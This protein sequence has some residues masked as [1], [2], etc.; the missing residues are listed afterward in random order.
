M[1]EPYQLIVNN[2]YVLKF[3]GSVTVFL[4]LVW[5]VCVLLDF[6][7][8]LD[9]GVSCTTEEC[10]RSRFCFS[11]ED[12]FSLVSI[13]TVSALFPFVLW[14]IFLICVKLCMESDNL[15]KVLFNCVFL[16][17]NVIAGIY[18]CLIEFEASVNCICDILFFHS[19]MKYGKGLEWIPSSN[20]FP[21]SDKTGV[22]P[23]LPLITFLVER[24]V[25]GKLLIQLVEFISWLMTFWGAWSIST[26][27]V[28]CS[29]NMLRSKQ[30]TEF[31]KNGWFVHP[32]VL[33]M[34]AA[35]K[36]F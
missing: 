5:S 9:L 24:S 18:L 36:T 25:R 17:K 10:V 19:C 3:W 35:L 6:D 4:D 8:S 23:R 22:Q 33:L 31:L 26:W 1:T 2:I 16:Y 11:K 27:V 30:L 21:G 15:L 7:V 13:A 12:G 29:L 28:Y 34:T 14:N 32:N 20:N